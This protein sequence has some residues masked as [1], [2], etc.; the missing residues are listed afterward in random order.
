MGALLG[1]AARTRN[2]NLGYS[3]QTWLG[4]MRHDEKAA[5][6]TTESMGKRSRDD[7]TFQICEYLEN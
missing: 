6:V 5:A 4:I 2:M 1:L 3:V 7:E